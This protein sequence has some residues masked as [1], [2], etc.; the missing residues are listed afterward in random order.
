M[1]LLKYAVAMIVVLAVALTA[2]VAYPAKKEVA[3]EKGLT[4]TSKATAVK[5][6]T[7]QEILDAS[8]ERMKDVKSVHFRLEMIN[9]KIA[10]GPDI[11]LDTVEGDAVEP[12]RVRIKTNVSIYGIPLEVE[13]IIADGKQYMREPLTR[14]WTLLGAPLPQV[15]LFDPEVGVA[16]IVKNIKNPEKLQSEAIDGA[17]CYHLKG[18]L[19]PGVVSFVFGS[20]P[21][22]RSVQ[23]EVWIDT[24]DLLVRQIRL[25]GAILQEEPPGIVRTLKLSKFNEP[26]TIEPPDVGQ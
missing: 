6:L 22:S 24:G 12:G 19:D 8:R 5:E 13:L 18:S 16:N 3:P 1:R 14:R 9:G 23:A 4:P 17:D 15:N 7:A 10:L 20:T 25:E 11:T 2:Y 21:A 26:V